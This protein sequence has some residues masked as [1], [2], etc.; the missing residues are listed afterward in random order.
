MKSS[1]LSKVKSG[2]IDIGKTMGVGAILL[3]KFIIFSVCASL[4]IASLMFL[5]FYNPYLLGIIFGLFLI[6][7]VGAIKEEIDKDIQDDENIPI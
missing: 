3:L 7:G 4:L 2:V 5:G 6:W 1:F